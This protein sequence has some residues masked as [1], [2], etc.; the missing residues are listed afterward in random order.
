MKQ[1]IL[2][3]LTVWI[4]CFCQKFCKIFINMAV[5]YIYIAWS[6]SKVILKKILWRSKKYFFDKKFSILTSICKKMR[7]RVVCLL[8]S[9]RKRTK[10]ALYSERRVQC[11]MLLCRCNLASWYGKKMT[12][13]HT[14]FRILH[15]LFTIKLGLTDWKILQ[16]GRY[17]TVANVLH[18]HIIN[19]FITVLNY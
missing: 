17:S 15:Y 1:A 18:A 16:S 11:T 7:L 13:F 10:Q 5:F 12:Q 6:L 14:R 9:L 19:Y 8:I 2:M 4:A 3:L